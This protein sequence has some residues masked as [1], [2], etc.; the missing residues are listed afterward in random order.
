VAKHTKKSWQH[1]G[2]NMPTYRASKPVQTG[3]ILPPAVISYLSSGA[4]EGER[5]E[6]LHWAA[7]QFFAAGLSQEEA[8][9]QLMP[10]ALSDGLRES[11]SR[12]CI[13]SAYRS[14][15][16]T[17]PIK[18]AAPKASN[19]TRPRTQ[20]KELGFM[21]ALEA[22]FLPGESIAVVEAKPN[23]DGEWKPN[24][25]TIK[26]LEG[27][28]SWVSKLKDINRLFESTQGGAFIAINPLVAG[29][30]RRSND[31]ISAYRHVLVE[32]DGLPPAEQLDK[33]MAS[34]LPL[35]AVIDSGGKSVHGWVRVDAA[36][37][38]E[39]E[40]RRDTVFAALGCDPKNKDLARV[41]RCPG[42]MR[43]DRLQKVMHVNVGA[44]SWGEWENRNAWTP[45]SWGINDLV[46]NG[47]EMP[48][49]VIKG[50]LRKGCVMQIASGPKMRK[51]F[52]L[53]DLALS[54][55]TGSQWM[56]LETTQGSVVYADAENQA[57]L[58]RS[59]LPSVAESRGIPITADL[60][61]LIR[62]IPLRWMLRGKTLREIVEGVTRTIK[63][64]KEP[65]AIA[66]L[67]PLYL[68]LRGAKEK[69][70]EEVTLAL[71]E[72]DE[73]CR[74]IGC[75][76]VFVHH[77]SKGTQTGKASM[78]RSSGSGALSRFPDAIITLTPPDPPQG[79]DKTPPEWDATV[80]CDLRWFAKMDDFNVYWRGSHYSQTPKTT[81]VVKSHREGSYADKYGA[82]LKTMPPLHREYG[83]VHNCE[84]S[85]WV[86][87]TCTI[88]LEEAS[89]IFD[90]LRTKSYGILT[91]LGDGK[92]QGVDYDSGDP[93]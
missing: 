37:K 38:E 9:A 40:A 71:E 52:L 93:F 26:T 10:R 32:W 54:V 44:K 63:A 27:W 18:S 84:C 51:S 89:K 11:E 31:N 48:P 68:L 49:E 80:S 17:E 2:H 19:G 61:E 76:I 5:N 28:R 60:N 85:Q 41:S 86:A 92:W 16:V 69:E 90:G 77:F 45:E 73:L 62:F 79:K 50:V 72:L 15:K 55:A 24:R 8:E 83:N 82:A 65:P 87:K 56:G 42:A 43:G 78:D 64:M 57:A 7:Q 53:M 70:A 75:A 20:A 12:Q 1:N 39:W 6:R 46:E 23:E 4:A 81:Y 3:P 58:I 29:S 25:A 21:D 36:T 59:R 47:P 34:G 67:E 14:T 33:L 22:A 35:S 88:N 30:D 74:S 91:S 13:R 66:I